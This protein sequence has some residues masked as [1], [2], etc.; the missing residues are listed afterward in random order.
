MSLWEIYMKQPYAFSN[1]QVLMNRML[2]I[3]TCTVT[4]PL[5]RAF[6]GQ[7]DCD[8]KKVDSVLIEGL[9]FLF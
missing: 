9:F 4:T 2:T 3:V 8:L 5:L 1:S 6:F 7:L